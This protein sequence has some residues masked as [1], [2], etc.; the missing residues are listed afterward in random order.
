M[1]LCLSFDGFGVAALFTISSNTTNR[2]L[3]SSEEPV[4]THAHIEKLKASVV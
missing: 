4:N 2:N 3:F 1:S